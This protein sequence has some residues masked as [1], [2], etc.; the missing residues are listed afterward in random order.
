MNQP[1]QSP[2]SAPRVCPE[3]HHASLHAD[4]LSA[5]LFAGLYQCP[6][7]SIGS[8]AAEWTAPTISQLNQPKS[9]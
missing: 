4:L 6:A 1:P 9:P 5:Q 2:Q 3:C 7:C 8:P